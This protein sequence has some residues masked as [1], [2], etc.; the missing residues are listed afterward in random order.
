MAP[1][2]GGAASGLRPPTRGRR[3]AAVAAGAAVVLLGLSV[4]GWGDDPAASEP[5]ALVYLSG[6][7]GHQLPERHEVPIYRRPGEDPVAEVPTETLAWAYAEAGEWVEIQ[8]AEGGDERGWVA[9]YF[10]RGELHL[11]DPETPGCPVPAGRTAGR[12]DHALD[13]STKVRPVDL[14][15][16]Q[17]QVRV[18]TTGELWWVARETLS[19]RPGPNVRR[20]DAPADCAEIV[21]EPPP[22]HH[23][24]RPTP[25]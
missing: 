16:G 25:P 20:P 21:M 9:D 13:P 18:L 5:M 12:V 3:L 2:R 19:E 1:P 7:D 14:R 15:G 10:L 11:V 23:V 4:P 24:Y 6:L 22:P 17:A 8:F